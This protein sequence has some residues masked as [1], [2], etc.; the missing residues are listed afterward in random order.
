MHCFILLNVICSLSL[1][2]H[3]ALGRVAITVEVDSQEVLAAKGHAGNTRAHSLAIDEAPGRAS[4][5]MRGSLTTTDCGNDSFVF[6][7]HSFSS[8]PEFISKS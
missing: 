3:H 2:A 4:P 6:Q 8:N 7:Y 5:A 1:L